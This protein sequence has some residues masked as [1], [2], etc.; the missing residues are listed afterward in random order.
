LGMKSVGK[1]IQTVLQRVYHRVVRDDCTDIA[2]QVSFFFVLSLFPFFLVIA[3]IVGWLPSTTLWNSFVQW[4]F[5]YFPRLSR[6]SVLEVVLS[7]SQWHTG[8][9]SFGIVTAIW[10]AASGFV[11]LMEALSIAY[12][13]R[14]T[15]G[16]WKKRA[17]AVGTTLGSAV[18][19]LASFGLW[20]AGEWAYATLSH[21]VHPSGS[22]QT[23]WK[24]V[25]W[26]FTLFLLI[27][28]IDLINYF[29]PDCPRPWRWVS[30]GSM[31]VALAFILGSI[32]LN[33]YARHNVMLPRIYGALAGFIVLMIWIYLST[34]ILLIGAETDTAMAELRQHEAHPS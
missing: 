17:I 22:F 15:R 13:R 31:F 9:L 11:S 26:L 34:V 19:F 2:A 32:G 25:W 16:Y 7:L 33:F 21:D 28:A 23:V 30:P 6:S 5:T 24:I 12:G 29:L 1:I 4:M 14:D 18:F 27:F 10:S 20:T 3:A 8:A